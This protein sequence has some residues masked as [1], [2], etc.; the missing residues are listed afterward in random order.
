MEMNHKH[1]E[2][3]GYAVSGS[4]TGGGWLIRNLP[5]PEV[6][7]QLA[8]LFGIIT[9][10]IVAAATVYFKWKNSR[11][12]KEALKRGYLNEPSNEE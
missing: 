6:M 4:L 1:V 9:G 5:T 7:A 11:E 2:A 10:V 3:V 8:S 12:Y